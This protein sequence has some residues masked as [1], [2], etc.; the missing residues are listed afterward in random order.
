MQQAWPQRLKIRTLAILL[1]LVLVL[2]ILLVLVL[3]I[4][5]V[6]DHIVGCLTPFRLYE[7]HQ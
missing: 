3:A 7:V 5:I 1:V 4:L 2:A 6:C